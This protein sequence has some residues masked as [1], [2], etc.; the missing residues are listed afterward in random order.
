MQSLA[1][2]GVVSGHTPRCTHFVGHPGRMEKVLEGK[3][4]Q[5]I[6]GFV[7]GC[8]FP[9]VLI[10]HVLGL[11]WQ[12]ERQHMDLEC[13]EPFCPCLVFDF[14]S[15]CLH[16]VRLG[17][18]SL[19]P[20]SASATFA[21]A[22]RHGITMQWPQCHGGHVCPQSP[23]VYVDIHP[24]RSSPPRWISL[25]MALRLNVSMFPAPWTGKGWFFGTPKGAHF[26]RRKRIGIIG[27]SK[28][29]A[30]PSWTGL[31]SFSKTYKF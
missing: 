19:K 9:Y 22:R 17:M 31:F 4:C 15:Q 10:H 3:R 21:L 28:I 27:C 14:F 20:W 12:K 5:P 29:K 26:K 13:E 11:K 24:V 8:F 30:S 25:W 18:T 16:H 1:P 2:A 23:Q 7:D 6:V